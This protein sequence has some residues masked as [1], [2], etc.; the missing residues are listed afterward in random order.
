[1]ASRALLPPLLL[2][3]LCVHVRA[4]FGNAHVK[5]D[6]S[7]NPHVTTPESVPPQEFTATASSRRTGLAAHPVAKLSQILA[8]LNAE[9]EACETQSHYISK[10]R[11]TCL[12]L[13]PKALK[14]QLTKRGIRCEGCTMKEHY[15]DR[16][17]DTV[18][19]SPKK[20]E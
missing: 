9:C 14:A 13:G 6:S 20:K 10:I 15:L 17:L 12:S 2:M 19:L 7:N 3:L 18:H 16:V 1:M 5:W 8:G 4:Q 11:S